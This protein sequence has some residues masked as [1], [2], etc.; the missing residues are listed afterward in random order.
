MTVKDLLAEFYT[1]NGIPEQG[2]IY[3]N[4]FQV[5]A[6]GLDLRLPNPKYRKKIVHLHDIQHIINDCDTSWKGE[7]YIAGW[8]LATGLWKHFPVCLFSFWTVGYC[9]WI[10]PKAV[11]QGFKKGLNNIGVFD[12]KLN[13]NELL[14]L[15]FL[16]LK[17]LIQK[18]KTTPMGVF[19]WIQFLFW[20]LISELLFLSP[21]FI[22]LYAVWSLII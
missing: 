1:Q 5:N 13:K 4:T 6:F 8:E 15:N 10:Y 7:G 11:F 22:L 18:E 14:N 20:A 16:E 9:L 3:N 21:F 12:L 19:Q 2:G 17:Q